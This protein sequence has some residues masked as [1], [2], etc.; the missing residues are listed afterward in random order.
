MICPVDSSALEPIVLSPTITV[1]R[2]PTCSG[3]WIA[4]EAFRTLTTHFMIGKEEERLYDAHTAFTTLP[5]DAEVAKYHRG[6][7]HHY[8]CPEGHGMMSEHRYA[9]DSCVFIDTC[10]VCRGI[11]LD[12]HELAHVREHLT[13]DE[14]KELFAQN[15]TRLVADT[16][17]ENDSRINTLLRIISAPAILVAPT[18][19][20][21]VLGSLIRMIVVD[22]V[23]RARRG[24]Y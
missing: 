10:A 24:E 12:V 13:F 17:R 20:L 19:F 11:W 22:E 1:D 18:F 15:F 6:D 4:A 23:R 16:Q 3:V 9:G 14:A 8:L 7:D 2:C 5:P 21:G